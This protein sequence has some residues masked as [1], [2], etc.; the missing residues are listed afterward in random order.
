MAPTNIYSRSGSERFLSKEVT[1]LGTGDYRDL[2]GHPYLKLSTYF[3]GIQRWSR[4]LKYGLVN[5]YLSVLSVS[6]YRSFFSLKDR[7]LTLGG[8]LIVRVTP[9]SYSDVSVG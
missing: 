9:Y 1:V 8:N 7:L 4:V 3:S 5:R 2:R 6:E